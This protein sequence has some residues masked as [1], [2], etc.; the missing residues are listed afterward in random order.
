MLK[1]FRI[2][3]CALLLSALLLAVG[4]AASAEEVLVDRIAAK[5]E[6]SV[7]THT[8]ITRAIPIYIQVI[9]ADPALFGSA[10]GRQQLG[11]KVLEHLIESQLLL[12]VARERGLE[13][14][15]AEVEQFLER[16]RQQLGLSASDFDAAMRSEGIHPDDFFDFTLGNLARMRMIQVDVVSAVQISEEEIERAMAE[17]FPDGLREIRIATS[18]IFLS[19]PRGASAADTDAVESRI[20]DLRRALREGADFAELA[21]AHNADGSRRT[22]G[23]IGTTRLGDLDPDYERAALAADVGEVVGPVRTQFGFHLIRL[24]EREEVEV[25]DA[26]GLRERVHYRLHEREV[27]RRMERYLERTRSEAFVEM[28]AT[29]FGF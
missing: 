20:L 19:V 11:E 29:D 15:R 17:R 22:G 5:V 7:I 1:S 24:D 28:V 26:D 18:H 27:T 25:A 6:G 8:D 23:R 2:L 3:P 14:T 13:P 10:E 16:Q 12:E 9:G 4:S 21:A